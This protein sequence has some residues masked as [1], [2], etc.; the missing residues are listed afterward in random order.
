MAS[1]FVHPSILT[2][3]GVSIH[4]FDNEEKDSR[5]SQ[6]IENLN[7]LLSVIRAQIECIG[8]LEIFITVNIVRWC[9]IDTIIK[10]REEQGI[11]REKTV[12][13][14]RRCLS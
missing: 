4:E 8:M 13:D 3:N 11:H 14:A 10:V 9:R 7:V 5:L 6:Y 12:H 2:T 1:I